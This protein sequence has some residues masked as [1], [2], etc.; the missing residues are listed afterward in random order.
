M[1]FITPIKSKN[2]QV[3][4]ASKQSTPADHNKVNEVLISYVSNLQKEIDDMKDM[5]GKAR[6]QAEKFSYILNRF[7]SF[8]EIH[9]I[10]EYSV[11]VTPGLR[12][13]QIVFNHGGSQ[14]IKEGAESEFRF[15]NGMDLDDPSYGVIDF[16]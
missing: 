13:L 12:S 9:G 10:N 16:Q 7:D 11:E 15:N 2:N 8:K 3:S 14:L 6:V 4:R 1:R 5:Q